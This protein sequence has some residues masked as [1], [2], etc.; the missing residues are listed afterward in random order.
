MIDFTIPD[1][2]EKLKE[3]TQKFIFDTV[4]P[5]EKDQ[6]QDN[7]G[8]H[9]TLR[10]ELNEK[11]KKIGLLSP[12]VGKKWGGL[13]LDMRG[14]SVIFEASGYSLLGPQA[15]NCSAPDEGNMHLLEIVANKEQKEEW[16]KPLAAAKIRSCF[17][18][19]EPSPGAGSDPS[20]LQTTA[21]RTKKGWIINGEKWFITGF[22]GAK[23]NI[24]MARTSEK[25][26]K[27]TGATMFLVNNTDPAIIKLRTQNS[28]ESSFVGGHCQIQFKDLKVSDDQ[29]LGKVGL[30]Y[31]YAQ[32]RLAP[33]RLTHC[34]RWLGAAQRA[35]DIAISYAS[36]R[37]A[38]GKKIGNHGGLAFQ[39]SDSEIDIYLSRLSIYNTA[40]LL[41]QG[42]EARNESS[43]SKVFCSEA[44]FRV[45]DK[46]MQTLG[47]MGITDDTVVERL[48]REI[49]PFRIYDG[50]SEVH[51]WAIAKRLMKN[52]EGKNIF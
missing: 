9:D 18:M 26:E 35:H 8:P 28:M 27:G 19:T 39:L 17:S 15:M 25:I 48:F 38:F 2:I 46:A 24:I 5:M 51:R 1:E 44:A 13:G 32:V 22:N 11:A 45:V 52:M 14:M 29:V 6:R 7:H 49:R 41:D 50:P 10:K 23:L 34:M 4:I 16:L 20:M 37:Y 47:G 33:A 31:K 40:W 30:G 43:M 12:S 21:M 3:T 36:K 42:K